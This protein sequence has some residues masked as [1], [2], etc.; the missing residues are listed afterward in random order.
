LG[1]KK[2]VQDI[3][4]FKNPPIKYEEIEID[5]DYMKKN[6]LPNGGLRMKGGHAN[7]DGTVA[8][9]KYVISSNFLSNIN[10]LL[11][12]KLKRILLSKKSFINMRYI[13]FAIERTD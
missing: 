13:I 6:L 2:P 11:K 4:T 10:K 5:D 7:Y 9:M 1:I 3:E 8:I 12:I